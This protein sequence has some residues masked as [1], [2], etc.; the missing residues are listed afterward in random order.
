[1]N[2]LKAKKKTLRLWIDDEKYYDIKYPSAGILNEFAKKKDESLDSTIDFLSELGLPK[3][4]SL[5]LDAETLI[6]VVA[7]L[8]PKVEKKS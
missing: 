8:T 3:E 5:E 4:V 1:M 7:A 6:D 2:E